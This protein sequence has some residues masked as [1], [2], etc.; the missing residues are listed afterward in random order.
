MAPSAG[1]PAV[2]WQ[3]CFRGASAAVAGAA[4]PSSW[5]SEGGSPASEGVEPLESSWGG[6]CVG[7]SASWAAD[8]LI[9]DSG[10]SDWLTE[11]SGVSD[12][13]LA[14][15]AATSFAAG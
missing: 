6:D 14:S 2:A 4:S 8:W 5:V 9:A 13:L 1:H 12:W 3:P 7:R 15:S 11:D 10:A